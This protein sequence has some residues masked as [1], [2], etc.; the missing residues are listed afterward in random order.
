MLW[1]PAEGTTSAE[2]EVRTKMSLCSSS[3]KK[4]PGCSLPSTPGSW[5]QEC[6]GYGPHS[7]LRWDHVMFWHDWFLTWHDSFETWEISK[8][9]L[10]Q[11]FYCFHA[12]GQYGPGTASHGC[13]NCV[14]QGTWQ[15]LLKFLEPQSWEAHSESRCGKEKK[16]TREIFSKWITLLICCSLP[17]AL[18][19]K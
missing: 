15:V 7:E 10:K 2:S 11:L 9:P 16:T 17:V 8:W 14:Q 1:R 6:P 4:A 3:F 13:K 5:K 19:I 18:W 12:F